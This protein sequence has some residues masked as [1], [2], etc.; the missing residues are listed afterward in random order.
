MASWQRLEHTKPFSPPKTHQRCPACIVLVVHGC[1]KSKLR[2]D[3]VQLAAS[4][5]Q[6]KVR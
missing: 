6:E 5:E 1:A 3:F 4:R 2:L